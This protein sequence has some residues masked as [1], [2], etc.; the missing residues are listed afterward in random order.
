MRFGLG[1]SIHDWTDPNG[2]LFLQ[3]LALVA[4]F[5]AHLIRLM[6]LRS[7]DRD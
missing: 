7:L 3:T 5:E 2:R 6:G 4:E 1:A